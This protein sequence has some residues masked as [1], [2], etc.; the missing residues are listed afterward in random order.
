M[1]RSACRSCGAEIIWARTAAGAAMPV[2]A[3]P[4][5]AGKITLDER[6]YPPLAMVH[7][8]AV[9]ASLRAYV[10]HFATCPHG[11]QWRKLRHTRAV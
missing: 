4:V 10:A 9:P 5:P 2:D 6:D 7:R 3:E 8:T 11:D 1:K